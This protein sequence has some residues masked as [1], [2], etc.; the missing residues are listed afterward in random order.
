MM[1]SDPIST[2]I[3]P[4]PVIALLA[5]LV[6]INSVNP[7][8]EGGQSEAGVVNYLREYFLRNSID[9]WQQDAFPG[10]P[11]LIARLPGENSSR[12]LVFEAHTDTVSIGGMT[13]PPFDPV[14]SEGRLYGR[15]SCDTKAGLAAMAHAAV[16][17][18]AA[19]IVPP[20]EVWVV[21]AAD[22]EFS[23]GGVRRL[24]QGLEAAAAIVSEPT[25]MRVAVA[26]KGVLRW[27]IQCRGRAAHSSRPQTGINA[28]TNMARVI[29]ALEED[30]AR[31]SSTTHPLLGNAT[32]NVGII[33]G[34]LQVNIVPDL[35][36]IELDRR[37]LPGETIPKVLAH[38]RGLI[39]PS[40]DAHFEMPMLEDEAFETSCET[41][42]VRC[43]LRVSH[44]V[45]MDP[46][47]LGVP[48]GTDAS[49]F[50]RAGIPSIICGPGSIDLAHGA[51]EYVEISQVE[52]ATEFYRRLMLAFR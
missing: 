18:K 38:Y 45:G 13:I 11:N 36:A 37:L 23:F 42:L 35:C 3:P 40:L 20:C 6:R 1:L 34:G 41:D 24:L 15:G 2:P 10:R 14:I 9:T 26:S 50:S 22:E 12:R 25:Q 28:I 4:D 29:L 17:L 49:K 51:V 44:E 48:F 31:L 39:D 8:Y 33:E 43:A 21:A 27:R 32:L 16:S 47:P 52:Q 30:G 19:G 7:S 5:D 46:E